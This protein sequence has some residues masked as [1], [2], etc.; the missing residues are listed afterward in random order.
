[1]ITTFDLVN[2][3]A[4]MHN[5]TT[6]DFKRN[7]ERKQKICDGFSRC[8]AAKPQKQNNKLIK[9]LLLLFHIFTKC[10]GETNYIFLLS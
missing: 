7:F 6:N 3:N 2:L 1:M 9:T 10:V 8:V 4:R 5:Q